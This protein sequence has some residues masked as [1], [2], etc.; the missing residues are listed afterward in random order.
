MPS[1]IFTAI[2]TLAGAQRF[3]EWRRRSLSGEPVAQYGPSDC[4]DGICFRFTQLLIPSSSFKRPYW[5]NSSTTGCTSDSS[6]ENHVLA[7]DRARVHFLVTRNPAT[8]RFHLI[9][10]AGFY[11]DYFMP[12]TGPGEK[13]FG[14]APGR[15]KTLSL[16]NSTNTEE[17]I[18]LHRILPPL[19]PAG[20]DFGRDFARCCAKI[21]GRPMTDIQTVQFVPYYVADVT[22]KGPWRSRRLP[23]PSYSR[24]SR[25]GEW[26]P[27]A[28]GNFS[29]APCHDPPR[30][31]P[32]PCRL[33]LWR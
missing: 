19:V 22:T 11:R 9:G 4:P 3:Y 30:S 13:S 14:P 15:A 17:E 1:F 23:E 18:E 21:S 5:A 26:P 31:G 12:A 6:G 8:E 25:K 7:S 16:W 29:R 32:E 27:S 10:T 24:L 2:I 28:S 20:F 33:D